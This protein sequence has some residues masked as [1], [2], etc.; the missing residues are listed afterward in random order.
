MR[1]TVY[2]KIMF[3]FGVIIAVLML[4]N[5]Y[6][7]LELDR[8]SNSVKATVSS[9]VRVIDQAKKLQTVLDDEIIYVQKYLVSRDLTYFNL[10]SESTGRYDQLMHSLQNLETD[11][12]GESLLRPIDILHKSVLA[13]IYA[14]EVS[15]KQI[16]AKLLDHY[17]NMKRDLGS[18]IRH[19]QSITQNAMAGFVA[20]TRRSAKVSLIVTICTLLLAIAISFLIARTITQPVGRLIQQTG[21]IARG[22]FVPV[23]VSSNDEIALLADAVNQMSMK[24]GKINELKAEMMQ[25]ISHELQNPLQ[26][27]LSAHYFLQS[28]LS[29]NLSEKQRFY[30]EAIERKVKQLSAFGHQYLEIAKMES[31]MIQYDLRPMELPPL[32]Q[33]IVEE[34]KMI[35][36]EKK[37][38]IDFE[39]QRN[40]PRVMA[41]S[42]KTDIIIRNLLGNAVKYTHNGG[43]VGVRIEAASNGVRVC[44]V[45]NGI[46]IAPE[47]LNRI[48]DKFYR[49]RR[50]EKLK[51]SGKGVGLAVVKTLTEGQG[52]RVMVQSAVNV[53]STFIVEFP[54]ASERYQNVHF[55]DSVAA[56]GNNHA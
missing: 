16:N 52:G 40:V 7:L 30:L 14:G 26:V 25:Q 35:A 29:G 50:D 8:I 5:A 3:G 18:L 47:E 1:L 53:G 39:A 27:I 51:V 49:V 4:A 32:I 48:F 55:L 31:E 9:N 12:I 17:E 28:E 15:D 34:I 22:R 44:I 13:S 45:D 23:S 21:E 19:N 56:R 6:M 36:A 38:S 43:R 41:D 33:P 42:E 54:G 46:G 24:L 11:E 20:S 37:I 10:F 2:K